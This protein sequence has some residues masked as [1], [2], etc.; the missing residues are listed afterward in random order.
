MAW[1]YEQLTSGGYPLILIFGSLALGQVV[2][3]SC[4]ER[5]APQLPPA[6]PSDPS[7]GP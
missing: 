4:R 7:D 3:L 1:L 2:A 6:K 5:S